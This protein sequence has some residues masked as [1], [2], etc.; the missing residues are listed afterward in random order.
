MPRRKKRAAQLRRGAHRDLGVPSFGLPPKRPEFQPR[1]RGSR[2]RC[3]DRRRRCG[4][5][6]PVAASPPSALLPP[7]AK[8]VSASRIPFCSASVCPSSSPSLVL[9]AP[10]RYMSRCRKQTT[11]SPK[12][13]R[14]ASV[15][16]ACL[17]A[18]RAPA[19][20]LPASAAPP[21]PVARP[22]LGSPASV[23]A[24]WLNVRSGAA[25]P[26]R[27]SKAPDSGLFH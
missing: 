2:S 11:R 7:L 15:S 20:P 10:G 27:A 17:R 5:G 8:S 25:W 9:S 23:A 13:R 21:R 3:F 18:C 22:G 19:E 14:A 16:M 12:T 4:A 1:G 6:F 26:H 24:C